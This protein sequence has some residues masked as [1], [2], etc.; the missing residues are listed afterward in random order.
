[1]LEFMDA[2]DAA[3]SQE[4][5]LSIHICRPAPGTPRCEIAM[6]QNRPEFDPQDST[7][8]VTRVA[9]PTVASHITDAEHRSGS[10]CAPPIN[11]AGNAG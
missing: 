8:S 2:P 5:A 1:M 7:R 3:A 6:A 10:W 9:L 4:S 11:I